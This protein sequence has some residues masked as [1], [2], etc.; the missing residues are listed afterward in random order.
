MF[1]SEKPFDIN[2]P[3]EAV[4][5]DTGQ[6]V[7][8]R[9]RLASLLQPV[10]QPSPDGVYTVKM[11]PGGYFYFEADGSPRNPLNPWHLRN[12]SPKSPFS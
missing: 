12:R 7:E 9:L 5:R 10:P 11:L 8:T 1:H 4:H 6:V 2:G 3:L